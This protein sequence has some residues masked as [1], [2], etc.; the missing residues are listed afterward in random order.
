M[1]VKDVRTKLGRDVKEAR[2]NL[3]RDVK[4]E[5]TFY[6]DVYNRKQYD[7]FYTCFLERMCIRIKKNCHIYIYLRNRKNKVSK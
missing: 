1:D 2:T 7:V 6:M 4:E 3:G 5:R